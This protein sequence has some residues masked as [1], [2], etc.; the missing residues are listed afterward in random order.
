MSRWRSYN[1]A[2]MA[3]SLVEREIALPVYSRH[4]SSGARTRTLRY[5]VGNSGGHD[6]GS[7]SKLG[8]AS[9]RKSLVH[10][11]VL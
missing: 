5:V 4:D 8:V 6:D 10:A 2:Y 9:S 3:A 7:S 1:L 11:F